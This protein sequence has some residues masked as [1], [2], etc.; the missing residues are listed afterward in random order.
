M[1]GGGKALN[2]KRLH[3]LDLCVPPWL[4]VSSEA[5]DAFIDAH[6][7]HHR[8]LLSA[9]LDTF[10]QDVER[11]FLACP[12]PDVFTSAFQRALRS[13]GL[14][15]AY[16]AVRSSGLDEDAPDHSFAGQFSTFLYQRGFDAI[17]TALKR[18]WASG[19]SA[20]S[21]AYRQHHGLS[22][23]TIRMGV[24]VQLMID[25]RTAG[26]SFSRNPMAPL[27]R[28]HVIVDAVYG[29]GEG[30]VSGLLDAD[31]YRFDRTSGVITATLSQKEQRPTLKS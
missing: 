5:M 13:A 19:Y 30:L 2:L 21:L 4:C 16:V 20:R 31:H 22:T 23:D 29:L 7:L 11:A 6:N 15:D 10:S 8:L 27:D 12:L 26:V 25:A 1:H 14:Q 24:I 3:T 28:Q 9:D 17:S 18:C